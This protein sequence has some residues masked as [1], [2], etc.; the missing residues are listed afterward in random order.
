MAV[1]EYQ[2]NVSLG[3]AVYFTGERTSDDELGDISV[4]AADTEAFS[5]ATFGENR[6]LAPLTKCATRVRHGPGRGT[7]QCERW[8]CH[9]SSCH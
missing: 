4:T 7:Y 1:L 5:W 3:A 8:C 2:F 9:R 6:S